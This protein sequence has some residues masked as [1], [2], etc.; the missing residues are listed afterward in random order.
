MVEGTLVVNL[1]P[2][3]VSFVEHEGVKT[4]AERRRRATAFKHCTIQE[5]R[6]MLIDLGAIVPYQHWPPRDCMMRLPGTYSQATL[7]KLGLET[8]KIHAN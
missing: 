2:P 6:M 3:Y 7:D 8:K 1:D 4:G 5:L